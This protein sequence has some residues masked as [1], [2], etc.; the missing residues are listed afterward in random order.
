MLE[1]KGLVR[2]Q[3]ACGSGIG[4]CLEV[5]AMHLVKQVVAL[6]DMASYLCWCNATLIDKRFDYLPWKASACESYD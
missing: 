5:V 2:G 4:P 1:T 3:P 6:S